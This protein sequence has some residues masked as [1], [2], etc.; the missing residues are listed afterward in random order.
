VEEHYADNLPELPIVYSDLSFCVDAILRNSIEAMTE[1]PVRRI[2]ITSALEAE[3]L[4]IAIQD[5]GCGITDKILPLV[6]EYGF[7]T[8]QIERKPAMGLGLS[9]TR[10]ITQYYQGKLLLE[11]EPGKGTTVKLFLPVEEMA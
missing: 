7:T 6:F 3:M 11:S 10:F 2:I 9:M 5:T 8:K 4:T 1:M